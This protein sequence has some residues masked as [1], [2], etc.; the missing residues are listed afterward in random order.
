M[1]VFLKQKLNILCESKIATKKKL[2]VK[3]S[4]EN[5]HRFITFIIIWDIT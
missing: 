3:Q 2:F 1:L 5:M 4:K